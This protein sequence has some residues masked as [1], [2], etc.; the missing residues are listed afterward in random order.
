MAAAWITSQSVH[1]LHDVQR[2]LPHGLAQFL[3]APCDVP[4]GERVVLVAAI[5]V[6]AEPQPLLGRAG[7]GGGFD[8]SLRLEALVVT[9]Q[10]RRLAAPLSSLQTP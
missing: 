5:G 4:S 9:G 7:D 10:Q 6:D 3:E 1:A 2:E 8:L